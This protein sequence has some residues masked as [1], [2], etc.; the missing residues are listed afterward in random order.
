LVCSLSALSGVLLGQEGALS[1]SFRSSLG[2]LS[3]IGALI[4]SCKGLRG[5]LSTGSCL[6]FGL[7][8]TGE[9]VFGILLDLESEL[10]LSQG[11]I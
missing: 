9:R 3:V 11:L 2:S 5:A 6:G 7:L 8:G 4:S 1:G 10:Q